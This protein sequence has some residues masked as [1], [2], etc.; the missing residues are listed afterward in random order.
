MQPRIRQLLLF[1]PP[2]LV[3]ALNLAHPMVHP[4]VYSGVLHQLDW[5]L[6]LHVINLLLFPLLGLAAYL[7]VQDVDNV[8][9]T[10]SKAAIAVFV[11]IY[12]AFDAL[13][14][15]GTG[16]LVQISQTVP[17]EQR[18]IAASVVNA[19]Y[20][21]PT[22]YT[23]AAAGS[24][25]W[26][27]AMLAAAVAFNPPERR[28]WVAVVALIVFMAGGWARTN[29]VQPDGMMTRAWWLM[30]VGMGLLMFAVSKPRITGTLLAMAGALFGAL[31][32]P[33]TGPL[34]AF[35]FL[36]GALSVELG[37]RRRAIAAPDF[38]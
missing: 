5:W 18:A 36:G 6:R 15:I 9:A 12:A 22:L 30:T 26:V 24:I 19:F 11:P 25:A 37:K 21:S 27:I 4:P 38:V 1:G 28:R 2:V 10:V 23:I 17:A 8:A 32:V 34:G 29:L 13:M 20:D 33:P 35:C 7:L 16:T 14:G 31:H 3:G